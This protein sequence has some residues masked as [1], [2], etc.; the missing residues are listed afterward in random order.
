MVGLVL[1]S[2]SRPLAEALGDLL[3]R[4]VDPN[5]RLTCC[6]GVGQDRAELGTDAIEIQQAIETVYSEDGVLVLIDM[7]G[8]ILNAE[9]AREFL[10]LEQQA[11]V[12]LSSAPLVEGGM[13]AA[14]QA[15]MGASLDAVAN[16]A[17]QSLLPKQ[18]QVQ[19]SRPPAPATL[20]PALAGSEILDVTLRNPHGL[21]LRPAAVLIKTLSGFPGEVLVENRTASR[22][23]V[24][25]RSLIDLMR[26]QIRQ[27]DLVRFS[28]SSPQ[29]ELVIESIRSL[30]ESH[31]GEAGKS[32]LLSEGVHALDLAQ[33]FGAS[34]GIAVGRP[35]LLDRIVYSVPTYM[36]ESTSDIEREIEKLGS[37][38]AAAIAEFDCRIDR[39]KKLLRRPEQEIFDAQRMIFDDPTILKEVQAKIHGEHLNAAAAWHEIL[40]HYAIDRENADDPYL[41]ARAADFRE[42]ERAVLDLLIDEQTGSALPD[43]PFTEPTLLVCEELTPTLAEQCRRLS[44]AGVIQLGGGTTSHGAILARALGIPAIGGARKSLEQLLKADRVVINGSQG[45]LWI[46]PSPEVLAEL[47]DRQQRERSQRRLTLQES[48]ER[49]ITSDGTP[50]QVGGNASSANDVLSARTNGADL[51]GLFRSEFLFHHFDEEP[52]EHRQLAAYRE[53]LEPLGDLFPTTVRLLD[54]G[55]DK[56]LKFLPQPKETNPFLGTRGI[57]LLLANQRFF[58]AHLRALLRL[59]HSFRVQLLIPMIT[60]VSEILAVR[61][62]LAEIAGEL[63]KA[64][65][66]H[67]WPVPL[68]AMIET[69]SAALLIDQL[70]SHLDFISI[71]TND[72]TQYIL[73]AERGNATLTRFSDSLHP[74]VLRICEQV[75]HAAQEREVKAS[76]CG[77]IA[78]D[79]EALPIWLGLG[80]REFSVTAAAIPATKSLIRKLRISEIAAQF[81]SNRL[82]L[83]GPLDVRKFSR[84]LWSASIKNPPDS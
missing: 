51:I 30:V 13:G 29:P 7:G 14:V 42:V 24:L 15:K 37:A 4:L 79:P 68:G 82:S 28:V 36:V 63:T 74:A 43:Q 65:V 25:A 11:K 1:V 32:D 27:G 34:G 62:I 9:T 81:A 45:S 18:D 8:A 16:A 71:G 54:V 38:V 6:G 49:A 44:M 46:D 26:L 70:L 21:H 20:V 39:L 72:L 59:A 52:D 66:S 50:I 35:V 55:G 75:I 48:R 64:N 60:D 61:K 53:A 69:P 77:E 80:L 47:V 58:R 12:R 41:R 2:H 40:S 57:R 78:S 10:N 73:C 19:D 5:L 83:K 17:L 76:I 3:R 67:R 33:P 84:S 22:G 31:F 56:P 23:P